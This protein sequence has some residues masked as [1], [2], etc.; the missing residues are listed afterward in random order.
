[1]KKTV[2]FVLCA[3]IALSVFSVPAKQSPAAEAASS[4]NKNRFKYYTYESDGYYEIGYQLD[5]YKDTAAAINEKCKAPAYDVQGDTGID[6][7]FNS[8]ERF[9]YAY[10]ALF[11]NRTSQSAFRRDKDIQDFSSNHNSFCMY[12][13][14]QTDSEKSWATKYRS[15]FWIPEPAEDYSPTPTKTGFFRD[16]YETEDWNHFFVPQ[17][18]IKLIGE[19]QAE[20][21]SMPEY[22][23][24]ESADFFFDNLQIGNKE[25]GGVRYYANLSAVMMPFLLYGGKKNTGF[26]DYPGKKINYDGLVNIFPDYFNTDKHGTRKSFFE[27][28]VLY[29]SMTVPTVYLKT[30]ADTKDRFMGEYNH[31]WE[32]S[33]TDLRYSA[34]RW[35]NITY[36]EPKIINMYFFAM[37]IAVSFAG[38]MVFLFYG[39]P[40]LRNKEKTSGI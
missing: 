32:V 17:A 20:L 25:Y 6:K 37:I 33:Y 7:L 19:D 35:I 30:D 3:I 31:T 1:M 21:T 5:I 36:V 22:G 9:F 27:N 40:K 10:E 26:A 29:H 18:M 13:Y 14:F 8:I 16:L 12:I 28:C 39:L 34:N 11:F 4:D 2:L 15:Y 38:I 23:A 24:F